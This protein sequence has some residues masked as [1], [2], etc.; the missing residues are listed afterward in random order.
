MQIKNMLGA[1]S[2]RS[3]EVVVNEP[4]NVVSQPKGGS[5]KEG[6]LVRFG[7]RTGSEPLSYQWYLNG[8]PI[9]V[10]LAHR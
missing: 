4:V 2:S 7:C 9:G 5:I 6:G 1:V 3:A 8:E 10:K